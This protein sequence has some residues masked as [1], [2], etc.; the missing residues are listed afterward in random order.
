M[1]VLHVVDPGSPGGG[2]CTLQLMAAPLARLTSVRQDVLLV[3]NGRH[4]RLAERCGVPVTGRLTAPRHQPVMAGFLGGAFRRFVRSREEVFGRY[5]LVHAWTA[6]SA[7]LAA[8]AAPAR[9]RVATLTIGPVNGFL[10][11]L[12]ARA[13]DSHPTFLLATSVA[14]KRDYIAAGVGA[15]HLDVLRPAVHPEAV[16]DGSDDRDHVRRRWG[17]DERSFVIGLLCEPVSWSDARR[18]AVVLSLAAEAGRDVRLVVHPAAQR[19]V[20]AVRWLMRI[21][22][23][24]RLIV[25]EQLAEPWRCVHGLDAALI[26]GDDTT[27]P[28]VS[29]GGSPFSLLFGGGR[30]LRP[31]PGVMPA[32]WAMATGV[33]V[34]A[35][36][37]LA[38]QE[39]IDHDHTGLLVDQRDINAAASCVVRL[40]DDPGAGSRLGQAARASI[41]RAHHVSAYCVQLKEV[42]ERVIAGRVAAVVQEGGEAVIEQRRSGADLRG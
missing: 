31:M 25:D 30:A 40:F 41:H 13:I 22:H 19:R 36:R 27:T 14:V 2:A 38:M 7:L 20:E 37:S 16:E 17:V 23:A 15:R 11:R 3:G 39:V 42:Y 33:P 9:R 32:L 10:M 8:I 24:H 28:D 34:I 21:G 1:R 35:E 26:L 12:L 4:E 6:R 18:A 5:D 29:E